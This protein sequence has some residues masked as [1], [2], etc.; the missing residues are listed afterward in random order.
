MGGP[1]DVSVHVLQSGRA[2]EKRNKADGD[3]L[4]GLCRGGIRPNLHSLFFLFFSFF[5]L[6]LF[7]FLFI[8]IFQF[9]ASILDSNS[10]GTF[11]FTLNVQF[12]HS[13]NF[14]DFYF[15]FYGISLLLFYFQIKY[16]F[17]LCHILNSSLYVY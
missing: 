2:N 14:I 9:K 17:R 3:G 11:I 13:R 5:L 1:P 7:Y 4:I 12:E 8:F 16:Q 15:V 6:H 10:C